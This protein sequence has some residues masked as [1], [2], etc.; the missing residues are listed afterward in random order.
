M[1]GSFGFER[2]ILNAVYNGMEI[3]AFH[4]LLCGRM[5]VG[6]TCKGLVASAWLIGV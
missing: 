3:Y 6:D 5:H 4:G 2:I 1:I